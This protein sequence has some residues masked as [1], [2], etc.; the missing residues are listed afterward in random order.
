MSDSVIEVPIHLDA[1]YVKEASPVVPPSADFSRLPYFDGQRDINSSVPWLGESAASDA[2]DPREVTLQKGIHLHWRF[3]KA[4]TKGT[5]SA[6]G[7]ASFPS[8]PNR[9]LVTRGR[10]NGNQRTIEDQWVIE[11]DYLHP[12]GTGGAGTAYPV[13]LDKPAAGPRFRFM[14]RALPLAQWRKLPRDANNYLGAPLTAVGY[15]EPSFA[16]FYPNCPSIFG[17]HDPQYADQIPIGLYY[18]V[19]GWYSSSKH[20]HLQVLFAQEMTRP[21]PPAAM[22]Q[23]LGRVVKEQLGWSVQDNPTR[24]ASIVCN[25]SLVFRHDSEPGW[26]PQLSTPTVTFGATIT[27]AL[28]AYLAHEIVPPNSRDAAQEKADIEDQLEAIMLDSTLSKLDLDLA[29]KFKEARHAKGFDEVYAGFLWTVRAQTGE[30]SREEDPE[31]DVA[32][33]PDV[34]ERLRVLNRLQQTYNQA[35]DTIHAMRRQ[36][37]SDWSKYMLSLYTPGNVIAGAPAVEET[38]FF[39]E[40]QS[41][42]ALERRVSDAGELVPAP[43]DS[44]TPLKASPASEPHSTAREIERQLTGLIADLKKHDSPGNPHYVAQPAVAPRYWRPTEPVILITGTVA[45]FDEPTYVEDVESDG[46]LLCRLLGSILPMERGLR[47][48]PSTVL[49]RFE[50]KPR[51]WTRQPWHPFLLQWEVE[52]TPSKALGNLAE[53]TRNYDGKFI[54]HNFT[55]KRTDVD[56]STKAAMILSP[57]SDAEREAFVY[58]GSSLLTPHVADQFLTRLRAYLTELLKPS[59]DG[60]FPNVITGPEED[61]ASTIEAMLD[62]LGRN[63]PAWLDE[64]TVTRFVS[65]LKRIQKDDFFCLAQRLSGFNDALLMHKQTLQ[66]AIDDP[67]GFE[68]SQ[69][70]AARVQAAAGGHAHNAPQPLKYFSPI[71]TG[72]LQVKNLRLVSTFGRKLDFKGDNCVT[73][74]PMQPLKG[75]APASVFLPPR[76]AQPARLQFRWLAAWPGQHEMNA[77][78]DS[79]PICGWVILNH[80]DNSLFFYSGAGEVAGYL[81]VANGRVRWRPT[82]GSEEPVTSLDQIEN[83]YL[84]RVVAFLLR[85]SAAF[86]TQFLTDL[87]NAQMKIEPEYSGDPLPMGQPLALVRATL[88]LE[89]QGPPALHQGWKEFRANMTSYHPDSDN[90]TKVRFPI[91]LGEQDQLNDGLTVYWLEDDSGAYQDDAYIIPNYD[92]DPPNQRDK[93]CDFLYQSID[94]PPLTVSMLIDPRGVVHAAT[95]ILP[96]KAIRIP[97]HQYASALKEFQMTFL[98]APVLAGRVG[99]TG[100]T[101]VGLPVIDPPGYEWS[102][103]EQR[104]DDWISPAIQARDLFTPFAGPTEI[105]EGWL[106]LKRRDPKR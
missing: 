62:S 56:L 26:A 13:A 31:A 5:Q 102:W 4:L 73:A 105:R 91:R 79:T 19:I 90:F 47:I 24:D 61:R 15:G 50:Y 92:P 10:E 20:D 40:H 7:T 66:I 33:W 8:L 59:D 17:F 71:R 67:M 45:R 54:T 70:L 101:T 55:L 81:E 38:R 44:G 72:Q 18:R 39:I 93:K 60:G 97:P 29:A 12:E 48:N 106:T 25:G 36:L 86:F 49:S 75:S 74:T 85:G 9:W 16:A 14:G 46:L 100:E 52:L 96:I 77:H 32:P 21:G 87:S 42:P 28:S 2:F 103:L 11:S 68:E 22:K 69:S 88:S 1:L 58:K 98:T 64:V 76:L 37:Y 84:R 30:S 78:P 41:L 53:P 94:D 104:G 65:V 82:P 43:G 35:W 51:V 80:L 89:I 95:G 83:I 63:K 23:R 3:P 34:A 6:D 27:E 99:G 57:N